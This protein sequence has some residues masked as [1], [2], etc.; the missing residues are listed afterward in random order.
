MVVDTPHSKA[1]H[2]PV[3]TH[4]RLATLRKLASRYLVF[5]ICL[6]LKVYFDAGSSEIH[7]AP[8]KCISITSPRNTLLFLNRGRSPV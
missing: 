6:P 5:D 4:P 2:N 8:N 3:D 7:H 1:T